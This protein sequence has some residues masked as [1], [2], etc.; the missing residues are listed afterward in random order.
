MNLVF[1]LV[2]VQVFKYRCNR[3]D[4]KPLG[5]WLTQIIR[6]SLLLLNDNKSLYFSVIIINNEEGNVAE[7]F[8]LSLLYSVVKE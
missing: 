2:V 6:V 7:S 4:L 5:F 8:Y 1:L 3:I